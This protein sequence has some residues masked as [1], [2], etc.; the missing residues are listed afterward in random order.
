[1]TEVNTTSPITD[2]MEETPLL[3]KSP[4]IW[5]DEEQKRVR[6]AMLRDRKFQDEHY[7]KS[8]TANTIVSDYR[9]GARS[10]EETIFLLR[11]YCARSRDT[12]LLILEMS[13]ADEEH[14]QS[15]AKLGVDEKMLLIL[16]GRA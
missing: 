14:R 16:E 9:I 4:S 13:G 1:M 10:K 11:V 8:Q 2:E 15:L 7:L 3:Q 12:S 5:M 6:N